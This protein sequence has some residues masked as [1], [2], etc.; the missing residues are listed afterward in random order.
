MSLRSSVIAM[1]RTERL[2]HNVLRSGGMHG[3]RMIRV[4]VHILLHIHKF[5]LRIQCRR[6][7]QKFTVTVGYTLEYS[8]YAY[9]DFSNKE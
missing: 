1:C 3:V 8:F 2:L 5:R 4:Y 6:F 9:F 7:V